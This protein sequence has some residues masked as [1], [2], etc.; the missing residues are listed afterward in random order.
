MEFLW[1]I[2]AAVVGIA[3]GVAA[4]YMYRKDVAEK[5]IGRTEEYAKKLL[6]DATRKA[7][8]KKKEMLLEAKE[9]I[10]HLKTEL[11]KEIRTRRA[12]IQRSERRTIQRE[13]TLDKREEQLDKRFLKEFEE[14]HNKQL[15]NILP[16][17]GNEFITLIKET[18]V[19]AYI[20]IVELT[21]ASDIIA[22]RTY[23]YFFPLFII[24]II[25]L[26]L[27]LGLTKVV[28]MME[29]KLNNARS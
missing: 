25:Y 12:E 16:A 11:D 27:T 2:L 29:V 13:E 6:D 14:G 8:D 23:D 28:N 5:K 1:I 21:K 22:S 10:L 17:L 3:I 26:I 4:G 18:S 24:A 19:G 20:G 9:E 15:K 7:D